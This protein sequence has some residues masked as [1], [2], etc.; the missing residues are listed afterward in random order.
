M[1]AITRR[2]RKNA[3]LWEL[4]ARGVVF[5]RNLRCMR[6][7]LLAWYSSCVSVRPPWY[8]ATLQRLRARA[9]YWGR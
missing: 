5:K 1:A 8:L 7:L 2:F 3:M 4:G 6:R 9:L